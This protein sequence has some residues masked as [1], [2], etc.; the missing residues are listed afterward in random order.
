MHNQNTGNEMVC[1]DVA[2]GIFGSVYFVFSIL[3]MCINLWCRTVHAHSGMLRMSYSLNLFGSAF[4]HLNETDA[5]D[6]KKKTTK[7]EMEQ[8]RKR[9]RT[10]PDTIEPEPQQR[11]SFLT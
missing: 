7:I 3:R 8:L 9:N 1:L 4:V 10:H 11:N 6:K 2:A 5:A